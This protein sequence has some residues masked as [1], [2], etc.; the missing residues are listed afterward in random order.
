MKRIKAKFHDRSG[1]Y[2]IIEVSN[3]LALHLGRLLVREE[4]ACLIEDPNF[5]VT[6]ILA[7]E[8]KK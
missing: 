3:T 6:I 7:E 5:D 2:E 1:A 8:D 4:L